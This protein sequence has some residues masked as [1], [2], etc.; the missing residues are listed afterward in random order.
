M[1]TTAS[2]PLCAITAAVEDGYLAKE[3]EM[4]FDDLMEDL[5]EYLDGINTTGRFATIEKLDQVV[6]P[7]IRLTGI[8]G[9]P[10]HQIPIPLGSRDALKLIEAAHQAPFGK[11]EETIVDTSVRKYV[12][13]TT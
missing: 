1:A 9:T 11:G 13:T 4:L 5:G 6:D 7:R 10:E 2:D 12:V 3:I 8:N